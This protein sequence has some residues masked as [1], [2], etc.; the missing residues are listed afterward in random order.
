MKYLTILSVAFVLGAC[1]S[2]PL[3]RV[4]SNQI[5]DDYVMTAQLG[6]ID[7][8]RKGN[9]DTWQYVSDRYVIYSSNKDYLVEFRK[10]CADLTDNSWVPA[11]YIHDH[12]N[13][14][15]GEDT[16]RGCIVQKIYPIVRDQRDELR[17]LV[18]PSAQQ[19]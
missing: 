19:N 7:L 4:P 8:I 14:R 15:A 1:A 18:M 12:R 16:I 9:H 17:H 5:V 13:L 10:D 11:D 2:E 3:Y 6:E